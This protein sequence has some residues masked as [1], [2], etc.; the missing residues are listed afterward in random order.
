[1]GRGG[2]GRPPRTNNQDTVFDYSE[3][4]IL[5]VN[6]G[7]GPY[8]GHVDPPVNAHNGP[9]R[10]R[11]RL[12]YNSYPPPCGVTTYGEVEDYT[13]IVEGGGCCEL[14]G[15]VDHSGAINVADL[16]YLVDFLFFDGTAPPCEEEGNVDGT[17]G[18]NVADLTY[19]VE[20]LFFN[21]PAPPPCS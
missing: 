21:G 5:D 7:S 8:T 16:I 17:G 19:L 9:T 20:F 12:N 2:R 18:I 1:V 4:V 3:E 13:I 6:T 11:V 14:R 15:N 10:M